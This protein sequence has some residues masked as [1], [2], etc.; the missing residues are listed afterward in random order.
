M[1]VSSVLH[2]RTAACVERP[3]SVSYQVRMLPMLTIDRSFKSLSVQ[4]LSDVKS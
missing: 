3:K 4:M 2:M 1:E